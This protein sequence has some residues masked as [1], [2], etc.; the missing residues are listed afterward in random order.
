MSTDFRFT[1][2]SVHLLFSSHS[3]S[4]TRRQTRSGNKSRYPRVEVKIFTVDLT[5][6][7]M[8]SPVRVKHEPSDVLF[9]VDTDS[10]SDDIDIDKLQP[11]APKFASMSKFPVGC[12]V[13]YNLRCSPETKHLQAKS[14]HV[15]EV[16][17]HFENGRR[18]YSVKSEAS[19][20]STKIS[21]S[22]P[23]VVQ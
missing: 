6:K 15:E 20:L 21:S 16:F 2:S 4:N 10:E 22:M 9:S 5:G 1:N 7:K 12:K 14:A 8:A 13:W 3:F 23:L 17:I 19:S 11:L 18:V